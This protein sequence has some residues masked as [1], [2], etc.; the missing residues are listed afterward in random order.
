MKPNGEHSKTLAI[1]QARMGS[2]RLPGKVLA[3]IHGRPMLWHV[4]QRTLAAK[5]LDE[6]I[7]ATT[8]QPSDDVIVAF[9]Q[10]HHVGC[11]RGEENDVLDRYYQA[12]RQQ[13]A[14]A[15]VRIT[16]D[17][18]MIDPQ[19]VDKVVQAFL[20][21]DCDYASNRLKRTYPRGLDTEVMTL[22]A[23]GRAWADAREPYQRVH[24]T[25]YIYQNPEQF[26]ILS[27]TGDADYSAY[28]WT[29]DTVEDL[30]FVRAVYGRM[31]RE[32]FL[33]GEVVRLLERQPELAEINRG[34]V[35]KAICE[36]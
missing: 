24:A 13:Y 11:F 18:P 12:A 3:D 9:C 34:V 19:V 1:I 35:Q 5:T 32:G 6:V 30:E 29:V 16:S 15:V 10:E 28:R 25:P 33:W 8:T 20:L 21:D 23:L 17:C 31:A 26:K 36:G 27:V 22:R 14:G 7:V 2:T 4:I